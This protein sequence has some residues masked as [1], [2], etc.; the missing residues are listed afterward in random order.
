MITTASVSKTVLLIKALLFCGIVS[1]VHY[2]LINIFIPMQWDEYSAA[3]QTVSELSAIGA[4]TRSLWI[5]LCTFYSALV[6]LFAWGIWMSAEENRSL[7]RVAVLMGIYG[8]SSFFWPPMHQR[9]VLA[10]GGGT[11]TD[12]MHI[13]FT[14]WTVLLMMFS[15]GFGATAFG[16]RFRNY[17]VLTMVILTSFGILT[18]LDAPGISADLPTP[19]I[20]VWERINIGV[21]L[22]WIIVLAMVLLNRITFRNQS[23]IPAH[24]IKGGYL[25]I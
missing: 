2:I 4:P 18:G 25:F 21:F 14:I 3:S 13:A 20:G 12:T 7:R 8:V 19:W 11:L 23:E 6:V 17:S 15:I 1:S 22:L 9:E 5:S 16:K 10:A 24:K